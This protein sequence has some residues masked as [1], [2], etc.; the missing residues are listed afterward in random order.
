MY[1]Q[2]RSSSR[3]S[4][5]MYWGGL[6]VHR[7][8][9][10]MLSRGPTLLFYTNYIS[11]LV[12]VLGHLHILYYCPTA[13]PLDHFLI[14]ETCSHPRSVINTSYL[15]YVG[16][17]FASAISNMDRLNLTPLLWNLYCLQYMRL[18]SHPL[19]KTFISF[20][21]WVVNSVVRDHWLSQ[22]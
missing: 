9:E 10:Y 7:Y 15:F 5:K 12:R 11:S 14:Y 3:C 2:N 22:L 19:P 20:A 13:L 16:L 18:S 4:T 6:P 8:K 1:H 21:I 17:L